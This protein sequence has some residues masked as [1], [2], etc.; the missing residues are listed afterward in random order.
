MLPKRT[1]TKVWKTLSNHTRNQSNPLNQLL[2]PQM[3]TSQEFDFTI[4]DDE[5]FGLKIPSHL[6]NENDT[7]TTTTT[8]STPK[9]PTRPLHVP[10]IM[11][12][13]QNFAPSSLHHTYLI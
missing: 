2:S 3:S 7:N 5:I 6:H 10:R 8:T 13:L 12:T 4:T 11:Q 9:T 1:T